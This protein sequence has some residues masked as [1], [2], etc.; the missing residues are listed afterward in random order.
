MS[1]HMSIH[2]HVHLTGWF[3]VD[4][5]ATVPFDLLMPE[6]STESK[7]AMLWL[8]RLLRLI[9]LPRL[10]PVLPQAKCLTMAHVI[11]VR[12]DE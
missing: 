1:M 10:G 9:R 11:A 4:L 3:S 2:M 12:S 5:L 6:T 8:L 7:R